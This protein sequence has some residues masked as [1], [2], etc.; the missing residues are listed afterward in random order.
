MS[1]SAMIRVSSASHLPSFVRKHGGEPER[2]FGAVD[3]APAEVEAADRWMDAMKLAALFEAGA[4]ELDDPWF[5]IRLG[6]D[7]SIEDFGVLAYVVLNAPRVRT[8]MENLQRYGK[9]HS[10]GPLQAVRLAVVGDMAE[11]GFETRIAKRDSF[12]Q[13]V[14]CHFASIAKTLCR[15]TG[16]FTAVKEIHFQHANL[17]GRAAACPQLDARF[18]FGA[19]ANLVRFDASVMDLP[20]VGADR[21][22]LPV[23][24]RR[25]ADLRAASGQDLPSRVGAEIAGMLCDGTPAVGAVARQ[26]AMSSR[27]LQRR[28]AAHG[29]SFREVLGQIR[30]E[31]AELYLSQSNLQVAEIAGLLGYTDSTNFTHAFRTEQGVSPSEWRKSRSPRR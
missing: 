9:E 26:L 23:A 16:S 28:L 29:T 2:I 21:S 12:R 22:L 17:A 19:S 27:S 13:L 30:I 4:V 6:L 10:F 14:E 18:C 11:I 20:V 31:L 3:V 1:N 15:L 25:L 7:A 5:G 24:E 8:A